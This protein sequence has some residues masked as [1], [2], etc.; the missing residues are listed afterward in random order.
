MYRPMMN[1]RWTWEK[2]E[3]IWAMMGAQ[4]TDQWDCLKFRGNIPHNR[5]KSLQLLICCQIPLITSKLL[6]IARA[7]L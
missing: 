3:V 2:N 4:T 7:V 5:E 6:T 1:P